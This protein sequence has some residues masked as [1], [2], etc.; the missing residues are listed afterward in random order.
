MTENTASCSKTWPDDPSA[1]GVVGPPVAANEIKLVDVPAMGYTSED[2]P[3]PRGEV[4]MRGV[5]VFT[6]YYKGKLIKRL[7]AI[8]AHS[9]TDSKNTRESIDEEGWLHS[10]DVAEIDSVGRIKI[11]DRVKNIMKLAQ[12]EYV[13][14][15]KVENLMSSHPFIAQIFI[16]GDSLQSYLVGI[17]VPDPIPLARIASRIFERKI[18]S[19]DQAGLQEAIKDV[20]VNAYILSE[21]KKHGQSI[22]LKGSVL[23]LLE[24]NF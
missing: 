12:G 1:S 5:C 4:C 6:E 16:Y 3:N 7:L 11:I 17:I 10:G 19:E 23:F 15:E 2:K 14:L 18:T 24:R 22:G 21:F 8:S 20:R 13:A 9:Y